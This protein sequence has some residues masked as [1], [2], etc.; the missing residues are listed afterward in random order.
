VKTWLTWVMLA[1][2][3]AGCSDNSTDINPSS[4]KQL[5]EERLEANLKL[6]KQRAVS[7]AVSEKVF[8][9]RMKFEREAEKFELEAELKTAQRLLQ[10]ARDERA[11][12]V[13]S[14]GPTGAVG[15]D[16]WL[17]HL[18]QNAVLAKCN[19]EH[20]ERVAE[21]VFHLETDPAKF[22]ALLLDDVNRSLRC[23]EAALAITHPGE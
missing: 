4:P 20:A 21:R 9:A 17:K 7:E 19:V 3:F 15:W 18:E 13:D 22:E 8:A 14:E 6:K 1:L 10:W 12:S 23:S 16:F 2:A 11:A 5:E